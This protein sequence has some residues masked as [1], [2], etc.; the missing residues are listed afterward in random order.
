M[1]PLTINDDSVVQASLEHMGAELD[2]A[3]VLLHLSSGEY[4]S[5]GGAANRIWQLLQEPHTVAEL[6]AQLLTQYAVE[7]SRCRSETLGILN[8]LQA[9]GFLIV[10]ES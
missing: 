5:L 7:E 4:F 6:V 1:G 2:D 9:E 3:T 8:R 10:R